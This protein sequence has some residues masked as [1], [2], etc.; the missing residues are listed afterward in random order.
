MRTPLDPCSMP[1]RRGRGKGG[2]RLDRLARLPRKQTAAA[3]VALLACAT[4]GCREAVAR[5]VPA[6]LGRAR[7]DRHAARR[8]PA[9]LRLR[10]G[11]A[12]RPRRP[13]ARGHRLRGG[14]Q[15]LPA[16]PCPPTRRCSPAS[17]RPTTA[18]AT[19]SASRSC[20][21]TPH[22]GRP[23]PRE[24]V[25]T[26]AAVSAFVLRGATGIAAGFDRL[27]RR[28][29]RTRAVEAL[30]EQQ[31]DGAVSVDVAARLDRGP[32]GDAAS[33]PSSTSTSRTPPTRRP[34]AIQRPPIPTTA[35]SPTRTSWSA[36][37]WTR[38]ARR[39]DRA[40]RGGDLGPRRGP[41][42]PRRAGARLLP[43][44]RGAA[45]AA[46]SC[47]CPATARAGRACPGLAQVDVPPPCS[48]S[49]GLD[50]VGPRRRLAA[51]ALRTGT[52]P[53]TAYSETLYPR[54]HFG[55]SE[56][57]AAATTASASCGAPRPELY[58]LRADPGETRNLAAERAA[59]VA[60]ATFGW[61]GAWESGPPAPAG[62]GPRSR[63]AG[64]ARLRG[65]RRAG[66]LRPAGARAR[67]PRTRSR[68]TRATAT[69]SAHRERG[70]DAEAVAALHRVLA[71]EPGHARRARGAGPLAL[72]PRPRGRGHPRVR[73]V[74]PATRSAPPR[75]CART[76]PR[77]GRAQP[78]AI[79]HAAAATARDPGQAFEPWSRSSVRRRAGRRRRRLRPPRV[80]ADPWPRSVRARR[81]GAAAGPLRGA[82]PR[83]NARW[84]TRSSRAS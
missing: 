84:R 31:R 65:G 57:F 41:G 12:R 33:S 62:G 9:R 17:C 29:S 14:L 45:R 74:V 44:P 79:R 7:L 3:A 1:S 20:A 38:A 50:T 30:G 81:R 59:T 11:A 53:A 35:R 4:W 25:A 19:T 37:C 36:V 49:P 15:P 60:A 27:R 72:A 61:T 78:L 82:S 56:L 13:R 77:P 43:V 42:R 2:A 52:R 47:G 23:L 58:D 5:P 34:S 26:G 24:G 55:W 68:P 63:A 16:R 54:F 71:A 46:A 75:T 66:D 6:G 39:L 21:D 10:G 28:A 69:P 64:R 40:D 83:S 18:C 51:R 48:T 76:H 70:H 8:P 22:A 67:T 73:A 80:D 32:Q